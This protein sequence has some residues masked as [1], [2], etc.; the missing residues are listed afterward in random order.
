M[1]NNIKCK[2]K[3]KYNECCDSVC[4]E[5]CGKKWVT[6]SNITWTM[7]CYDGTTQIPCTKE[8]WTNPLPLTTC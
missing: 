4:C 5:K 3:L 6:E 8:T 1:T 2:H 7:P